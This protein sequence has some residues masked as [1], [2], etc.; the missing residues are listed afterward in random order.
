MYFDV[1]ICNLISGV[2][3]VYVYVFCVG[4]ADII[5]CVWDEWLVIGKQGDRD[6]FVFEIF[7]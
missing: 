6:E 7:G 2:V 1:S 4:V 3:V 5:M